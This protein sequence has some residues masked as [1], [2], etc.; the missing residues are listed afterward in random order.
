MPVPT[1]QRRL[2]PR[3]HKAG[4]AC[5]SA[6]LY[7][8]RL[9]SYSV[10]WWH[11]SALSSATRLWSARQRCAGSWTGLLGVLGSWLLLSPTPA[12][13][14]SQAGSGDLWS[15]PLLLRSRDGSRAHSVCREL[16]ADE[17]LALQ[18]VQLL[19]EASRGDEAGD[20]MVLATL[21]M[22]GKRLGGGTLS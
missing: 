12:S 16:L 22:L 8:R 7:L 2:L 6:S 13:S 14:K 9:A 3:P 10:R 5:T 19:M 15:S 11:S 18:A 17:L 20:H 4:L 1:Q 21:A